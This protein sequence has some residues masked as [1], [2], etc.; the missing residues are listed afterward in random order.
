MVRG[1]RE[2]N[3][4]GVDVAIPRGSLTTFTGVSGSGKSSL[5]FDTICQEGQRR[6]VESLSAY[7]R[8]FLGQ[9]EKPRVDEIEGLSPTVS[10]DQKTV[11]TN[12]RS[13]VG[14]TTEIYD[15]LRLL[16]SRLGTPHCPQCGQ[17]IS[18]QT[19]DQVVDRLQKDATGQNVQILAPIIRD[20]KGEYRKELEDLRK[21][22]W[23]RA[24]IDGVIQRLDEPISLKR[25]ER[26]T[27]E[28]IVDRLKVD[29]D[30]R[31]RLVEGIEKGFALGKGQVSALLADRILV[32]SARL[33]CGACGVD[34]P[35]LEP[36]AFSFNSPHGACPK[37]DGLGETR[38][39]DER[40][41]VPD[42]SLS[43][44][45]GAIVPSRSAGLALGR[46]LGKDLL[47]QVCSSIKVRTDVPIRK[48]TERERK[49]LLLGE[50][51]QLV[52][53]DLKFEGKRLRYRRREQRE[54]EGVIPLLRR[55]WSESQKAAIEPYLSTM[56]CPDCQGARLR[57]EALSVR[58]RELGIGAVSKMTVEELRGFIGSVVLQGPEVPVGERLLKELENRLRFL[59][60]VG[61]GYLALDRGVCTLSGGES[62]RIRL[63][64]QVGSQLRGILYVLDEPSIGLHQSDNQRLIETLEDLR[65][66]GNTVI[67]VE[68]DEETIRRSDLVIDVGPGAG[69]LGGEIVAVGSARDLERS[70]RSITGAYLS[71]REK[72]EVP[73]RGRVPGSASVT[74]RGARANNLKN[75]D[76][77]FPLGVFTCVTGASGSGKST[78]VDG[79][80]KRVLAKEFHGSELMPLDHDRVEG[81]D[82]LDKVIEIDQ[83]PI[84]RT[85]RSN[86]ATYTK[87]FDLVRDLYAGLPESKARGWAKG[88][89]SF[90]VKGGRCEECGGA[91]VQSIEMQFLANV[92]VPCDHCGGK[93]FNVATLEILYRGKNITDVLEMTVSEALAF[94]A[95]HPKIVRILGT[96]ESVGLGYMKLGQPSTTV[97]GGEAQRI[98]LASELHRPAT[99]R[100]LYLLDEPTTGLHFHD[101]R[102][103][104]LALR[105]LV[106]AGNTVVVI[107]HN[108]DVIQNADWI[109]D[110]GPAGGRGG[111]EL[112]F[113]GS[114]DAIQ[115]CE[116]S[117]TGRC[118]RERLRP[119]SVRLPAAAAPS[120][121][122]DR[123][124]DGDIRIEGASLHNLKRVSVRFPAGK[125]SVVT[126]PSGSGKTSLAFDTLF[127]EG[128][129]RFVECLSTYARQFLGRLERPPLDRI[130]GLAPAIAIDQKTAGRNPRSTV[131]T[132]TEIHDYLRLLWA[133][134][135][136]S[137]C[138][139]CDRA[140]AAATPESAAAALLSSGIGV[141]GSI[142][143][144]LWLSRLETKSVLASA[145][146]LA[147]HSEILRKE[148]FVRVLID[149]V[150]FRLDQP[151]PALARVREVFLVVDRVVAKDSAK[152]R[153]RDG[154]AQAFREGQSMAA[155]QPMQGD[156]RWFSEAIACLD[157]GWF[158]TE[159]LTPRHFSFNS[160]QGA[161]SD[162]QG[163]GMRLRCDPDRL[164]VRPDLP[165]F[166][167]A[168]VD[169]PGDFIARQDSYFRTTALALI[170]KEGGDPES[171]YSALS[172]SVRTA[173]L[174][175]YDGD[176][177]IKYESSRSDREESWSMQ[178]TWKGLCTYVE[179]WHRNATN[180]WW[181]DQLEP[182]MR[183][184][185]C[186]GCHGE[187]LQPGA[188][189]V[190]VHG[191]RI[192]ELGRMTV[193]SALNWVKSLHF[194]GSEALIAEQ[195]V[196][197]L[198]HRIGFLESVGLDYLTLNRGSTTLSGGE[199]QRIRLATQIGNRLT[200]VI[201]VLDEPTIGLHPRDT[202]RLL[203]TLQELRDLGNT[204]IV[205]EHDL[206]TIDRADWVVD[207]GPGAGQHGGQ[208]VFQGTLDEFVT[209]GSLTAS[210][211]TG[212]QSVSP[213]RP[214]RGPANKRLKLEGMKANNLKMPSL[215]VPLGRLVAVTGV[216]GSGKS[217]LV[218]ETLGPAVAARLKKERASKGSVQ[219]RGAEA[220]GAVIV[221][222][223]SPVGT[224]PKSNPAS[225][226]G[227]MDDIREIMA[228]APLAKLRGYSAGRFSFNTAEGR[229]SACEGRGQTKIEMHFLPDVW[230]ECDACQGRRYERAT[231]EVLYRGKSIADILRM[232]VDEAVLFFEN[233]RKVAE[234]LRWLSDVGLG[235]LQLGQAATTL[236]GGEAQRLKL[237]RELGGKG[238]VPT[239]YLLDEPTTGLHFDDI[240]KLL[241]V[242][243]RLVD[244]G[245]TVVLI[246]HN[247]DVI[248]SADWI[249]DLGPEGGDR[250]GELMVAGTPDEV[251][252][253][254]GSATGEALAEHR[255]RRAANVAKRESSHEPAC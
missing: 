48:L 136:T 77:A 165:L 115:E 125:M 6:F 36:R 3:L 8:Q 167:G 91:G 235:Y 112:V 181:L 35:E 210:Y 154:F 206:E 98:K 166:E 156:L 72:I 179:D 144:P 86:P 81:L 69:A 120:V 116:R 43:I 79:I 11:N 178:V 131:A 180:D 249:L 174:H 78:L 26:H 65:D 94:F 22:G 114:L 155:F 209:S 229:C 129:R 211:V 66:V 119:R 40:L 204:V 183:R 246:E 4:K 14:T 196:K 122:R 251:S 74:I 215:E 124:I 182:L 225:Y 200:G 30:K 135:G 202:Q 15:H 158:S 231:L 12:P 254:F 228:G 148:G 34:V 198:I 252:R 60:R 82:L 18:A 212:R 54:W 217:S 121:V 83:A 95:N 161:C 244:Q 185:E 80:L 175:G 31:S 177:P 101:T 20:R 56:T 150:E 230:L 88:R 58:F 220:L 103:L 21:Q 143:A 49:V 219:V 163:L 2:H 123:A 169:R 191:V 248:Q 189:A 10:I 59:S 226:L 199:A 243:H 145:K 176:L 140:L 157:C 245:H 128:Q 25:Y 118:L 234:M 55:L 240:A 152:T 227:V 67:V 70:D 17:V 85:P 89:F 188:R 218:I 32:F 134:L 153:I 1:A 239:L 236:S 113:A 187:R 130:E 46:H 110:L 184:D 28:V 214:A 61:L 213:P 255:L 201:Y 126:G 38:D 139:E 250:G 232:E 44:D 208:V 45:E 50:P 106:D 223:Q 71:G 241:S 141:K 237:A 111:G 90:N 108:L 160:H 127:A 19:P 29:A 13:T 68:H 33:A 100:T 76:V 73:G 47:A 242:L 16:Y 39:V 194:R 193:R 203:G 162:C 147:N 205:V 207:M 168:L 186:T 53:L 149:G 221:V 105:G 190:R 137:H 109:I 64:T 92:T 224:S 9:A 52:D 102:R 27:I 7:A 62:Q 171:P 151:L 132:T 247:L 222:D 253:H 159:E 84:G 197:E 146:E 216:S 57:S 41:V 63:A 87:L 93:R 117:V 51:R 138:P 170:A 5:A 173:I 42:R 96:L 75:I 238:K 172:K 107:E 133:R 99:G 37:C 164:I 142:L 97:S 192:G 104:L 24:R 195:V 23:V 233:H